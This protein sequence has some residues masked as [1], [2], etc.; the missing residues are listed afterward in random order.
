V[1]FQEEDREVGV[2]KCMVVGTLCTVACVGGIVGGR[3]HGLVGEVVNMAT[4]RLEGVAT[5]FNLVQML[6]G[7][8]V[9]LVG[10]MDRGMEGGSGVIVVVTVRLDL[11][12]VMA[13]DRNG[14]VRT[15]KETVVDK[16]DASQKMVSQQSALCK[17]L[18]CMITKF[19]FTILEHQVIY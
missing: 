11:A 1:G 16:V 17:C 13:W 2:I 15:D 4:G 19:C 10:S 18:S 9:A 8:E 12:G 3:D 5:M 6:E 14:E 7:M